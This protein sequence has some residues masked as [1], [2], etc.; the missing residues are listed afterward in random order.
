MLDT[1]FTIF[2]NVDGRQGR[3]V[4][5]FPHNPHHAPAARELEQRSVAERLGQIQPQLSVQALNVL[6]TAIGAI[7][8][9]V[10]FENVGLFDVLRWWALAGYSTTG[11][12]ESTEEYKVKHGQSCFAKH[13]FS[14]ACSTGRLGYAFQTRVE[15]IR[16]R[17]DGVEVVVDSDHVFQAV[18]VICT[19][20]LNVLDDIE[21]DPALPSLKI[22][23]A[24]KGQIYQG[25]KIHFEVEGTDL[26]S[27]TGVAFPDQRILSCLG[28][29]LTAAGN[30]H[31][32]AFGTNDS[33]LST[34]Q[35]GMQLIECARR[36][37][38]SFCVKQMVSCHFCARSVS[39]R[40]TSA[41]CGIT[42]PPIGLRKE[43]GACSAQT[44]HSSI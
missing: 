39:R 41:R 31:V 4:F 23:A 32:V 34:E 3:A 18:R 30:T 8:G 6:K 38:P 11:L 25:A 2:C 22:E 13:F 1:A 26:R 37:N 16:S 42:G 28:D 44:F 27:W 9:S 43:D 24:S 14:E 33:S 36:L 40:L 21:F 17:G 19:V 20:P 35:D 7:C 29:G 12:F 5:P 15:C 10:D